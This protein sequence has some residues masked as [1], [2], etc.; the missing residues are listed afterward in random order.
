MNV[1]L[2][3]F[4]AK[5]WKYGILG[6][7]FGDFLLLRFRDF[8][9][10]PSSATLYNRVVLWYFGIAVLRYC[11]IVVLWYCGSVVKEKEEEMGVVLWNCDIVV[12]W[13]CGIL[14]FWYCGKGKGGGDGCGATLASSVSFWVTHMPNCQANPDVQIISKPFGPDQVCTPVPEDELDPL[15][16]LLKSVV[17]ITSARPPHPKNR[18]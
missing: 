16:T 3:C 12:L 13:Y 6:K 14:V 11:G 8:L 10:S 15:K 9:W 17:S 18:L 1:L 5:N 4:V 7:V 2:S